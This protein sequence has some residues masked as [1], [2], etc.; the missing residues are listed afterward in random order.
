MISRVTDLFTYPVKSLSAQ[1]LAE[2]T[3]EKGGA[4]PFD[5]AYALKNG[6]WPFD[7]ANPEYRAKTFYHVLMREERLAGVKSE[8]DAKTGT[9]LLVDGKGAKASGTLADPKDRAAI[10]TF[11]K[12]HLGAE[13]EILSSPGFSFSDVAEKV[14]SII[15]LASVR[16]LGEAVGA[17]LDPLRFR[18]NIQIDGGSAWSEFNL[19]G[20]RFS[21][22]GVTFETVKRIERCAATGVDPKTARRDQNLVKA[23]MKNFGHFDMGIYAKVVEGGSLRVGDE[24]RPA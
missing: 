9:L 4:F 22:G 5:R 14:A 21:I 20:K 11:L 23:L 12:R 7:P 10:E 15:N 16:A 8:F 24:L 13:L 1:A 19:A 3:L 18:G 2:V 17:D 6:A